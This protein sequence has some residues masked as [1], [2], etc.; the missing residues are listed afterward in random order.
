M[1]L[2]TTEVI[3]DGW[4]DDA[5]LGMRERAE[6]KTMEGAIAL[7][8]NKASGSGFGPDVIVRP[9]GNVVVAGVLKLKVVNTPLWWQTVWW[10]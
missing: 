6:R 2:T 9:T 5:L 8:A 1:D 10:S 7:T 3:G 4:L